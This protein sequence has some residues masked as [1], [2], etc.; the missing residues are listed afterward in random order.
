MS[1]IAGVRNNGVSARQEL[2]VPGTDMTVV[3]KVLQK[4][5]RILSGELKG[6]LLGLVVQ[7]TIDLSPK[8]PLQIQND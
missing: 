6:K 4:L 1:V 5:V 2:T 8:W 3:S 7:M